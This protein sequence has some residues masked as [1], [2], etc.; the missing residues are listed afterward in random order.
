[1]RAARRTSRSAA[2]FGA[3]ASFMEKPMFWATVMCG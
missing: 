2:S 1:M 3:L